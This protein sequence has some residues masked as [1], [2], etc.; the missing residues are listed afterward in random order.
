MNRFK[1]TLRV[2]FDPRYWLRSYDVDKVWDK[3]LQHSLDIGDV[4]PIGKYEAII[5]GRHVWIANHPYASGTTKTHPAAY[6]C[7]RATAAYM[8]DVLKQHRLFQLLMYPSDP[9][10]FFSKTGLNK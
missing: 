6:S 9:N 1:Y 4:G 3:H 10:E 5:G 8:H 2:I 7:S